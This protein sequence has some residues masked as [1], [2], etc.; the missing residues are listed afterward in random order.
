MTFGRMPRALDDQPL[1]KIKTVVIT[2][3]DADGGVTTAELSGDSI[4][5]ELQPGGSAVSGQFVAR[6]VEVAEVEYTAPPRPAQRWTVGDIVRL[7]KWI[8]P[9]GQP[10]CNQGWI[11]QVDE[12]TWQ[13]FSKCWQYHFVDRYGKNGLAINDSLE[14][15]GIK[16]L[17]RWPLRRG[18]FVIVHPVHYMGDEVYKLTRRVAPSDGEHYKQTEGQ[19]WWLESEA[20][21]TNTWL[22]DVDAVLVDD[23]KVTKTGKW[24]RG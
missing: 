24:E 4:N 13:E 8:L 17:D 19:A 3:T 9:A 10:Y 23:V 11:G 18:D 1:T 2:A 21:P 22:R 7:P 12:V 16:A 20:G 6:G 5:L 14:L 15:D